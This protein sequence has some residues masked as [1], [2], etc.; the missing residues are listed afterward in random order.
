MIN[1]IKKSVSELEEGKLEVT[2]RLVL[3]PWA[4]GKAAS[5]GFIT[6][7]IYDHYEMTRY[8]D[9]LTMTHTLTPKFLDDIIQE[10]YVGLK[11]MCIGQ[12]ME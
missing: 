6:D 3:P 7:E 5:D 9:T 1:T 2:N 8:D 10:F 4:S 11:H 12:S